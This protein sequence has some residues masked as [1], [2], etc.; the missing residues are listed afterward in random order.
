MTAGTASSRPRPS[1]RSTII[2]NGPVG[3]RST[4][5]A[6]FSTSR[7]TSALAASRAAAAASMSELFCTWRTTLPGD[8]RIRA[9]TS[10]AMRTVTPLRSPGPPRQA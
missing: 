6:P 5:R 10:G 4:A 8:R 9:S 2:T 7:P 1:F 3:I